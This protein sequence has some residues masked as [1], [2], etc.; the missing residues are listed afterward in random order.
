MRMTYL[1]A[2]LQRNR[3]DVGKY[4][5]LC[6]SLVTCQGAL[7]GVLAPQFDMLSH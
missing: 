6:T 7:A 1:G 2:K 5:F 4:R 3:V